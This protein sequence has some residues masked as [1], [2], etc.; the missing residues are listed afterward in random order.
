MLSLSLARKPRDNPGSWNL[1]NGSDLRRLPPSFHSDREQQLV[2]ERRAKMVIWIREGYPKHGSIP[3]QRG[4]S[5]GPVPHRTSIFHIVW[6]LN[7]LPVVRGRPLDLSHVHIVIVL[8]GKSPPIST[9]AETPSIAQ[10]Q[11]QMELRTILCPSEASVWINCLTSAL[12]ITLFRGRLLDLAFIC[13][14]LGIAGFC[15]V[16][17]FNQCTQLLSRENK[18]LCK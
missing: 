2:T 18:S 6:V 3:L 15:F 4:H 12:E 1:P 8:T 10:H 13:F 5:N 17:R 11:C 16:P 7:S 14:P 9:V